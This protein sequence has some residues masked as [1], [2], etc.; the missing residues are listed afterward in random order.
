M[1]PQYQT[2]ILAQAPLSTHSSSGPRDPQAF[3]LAV[4]DRHPL[5]SSVWIRYHDHRLK[6]SLRGR[7]G[8]EGE[9]PHHRAGELLPQAAGG[10]GEVYLVRVVGGFGSVLLS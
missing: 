10:F 8:L 1:V 2:G 4:R 9:L 6:P 5:A 3:P 7:A